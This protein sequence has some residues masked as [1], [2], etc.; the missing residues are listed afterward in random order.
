MIL[1][2]G[3]IRKK[4]I[5]RSE[6][7]ERCT[8][9]ISQVCSRKAVGYSVIIVER[10]SLSG[11]ERSVERNLSKLRRFDCLYIFTRLIDAVDGFLHC[12]RFYVSFANF[13]KASWGRCATHGNRVGE[14]TL[15]S[16]LRD[17]KIC[18]RKGRR[19]SITPAFVRLPA[20][21]GN[22]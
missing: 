22:S 9:Q 12:G 13:E 5:H 2:I 7:S 18:E 19:S 6:F 1:Q 11:N 4:Q 15:R 14:K 16:D 8:K 20:H 17:P 21:A 3:N 10:K